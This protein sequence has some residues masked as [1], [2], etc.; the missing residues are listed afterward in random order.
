MPVVSNSRASSYR[1]AFGPTRGQ[2]GSTQS[3]NKIPN[4][5]VHT[6]KADFYSSDDIQGLLNIFVKSF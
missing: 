5:G 4:D 6:E 1:K 3:I 2:F